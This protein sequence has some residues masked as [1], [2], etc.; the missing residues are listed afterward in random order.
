[1][2][3][4]N[5]TVN[6]VVSFDPLAMMAFQKSGSLSVLRESLQKRGGGSTHF[7]DNKGNSSLVSLTHSMD[8]EA[9]KQELSI[10]FID[11]ENLAIESLTRLDSSFEGN[12]QLKDNIFLKFLIEQRNSLLKTQIGLKNNF[13]P[14]GNFLVTENKYVKP[15]TELRNNISFVSGLI[16]G[17]GPS[18]YAEY[19]KVWEDGLPGNVPT[20]TA[21]EF[22][23]KL[24]DLNSSPAQRPVYVAYGIGENLR[25]WCKVK[26]FGP[27]QKAQYSFTSE[28]VKTLKFIFNP[29]EMH[30]TMMDV[31][32]NPLGH[33]AN[34]VRTVGRAF[35]LYNESI[36][37]SIKDKYKE[38]FWH[39]YKQSWDEDGLSFEITEDDLD[40][41]YPN[42][43][44]P[45]LYL[46]IRNV[47]TNFIKVATGY[48]NVL[49]LLPDLDKLLKPRLKELEKQITAQG[50]SKSTLVAQGNGPSGEPTPA[51]FET[52]PNTPSTVVK[53]EALSNILQLLG[54]EVTETRGE[55]TNT[56]TSPSITSLNL[57][58]GF[59]AAWTNKSYEEVFIDKQLTPTIQCNHTSQTV[60]EKLRTVADGIIKQVE[61]GTGRSLSFKNPYMETDYELL[62]ILEKYNLIDTATEP[63][64]I[65]GE[66]NF[67]SRYVQGRILLENSVSIKVPALGGF[68]EGKTPLRDGLV[69]LADMGLAPS[70][71]QIV[72]GLNIDYMKEVLEALE[73]SP[74]TDSLGGFIDYDD[75]KNNP[76]FPE[77]AKDAPRP[78]PVFLFGVPRS[79]ILSIDIDTDDT[80]AGVFKSIRP[81]KDVTPQTVG[82]VI[83]PGF[84]LEFQRMFQTWKAGEITDE[85]KRLVDEFWSEPVQGTGIINK[86]FKNWGRIFRNTFSSDTEGLPTGNEIFHRMEPGDSVL[87][88]ALGGWFELLTG[89]NEQWKELRIKLNKEKYYQF[90]W[91]AFTGLFSKHQEDLNVKPFSGKE[92]EKAAMAYNLALIERLANVSLTGRVKTLPMFYLSSAF[93]VQNRSCVVYC[94]E[95]NFAGT[96]GD[97]DKVSWISGM[98]TLFGFTHTINKSA[99]TSEFSLARGALAMTSDDEDYV[100]AKEFKEELEKLKDSIAN[101]DDGRATPM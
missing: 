65:W 73:T 70:P 34:D 44:E 42:K 71:F 58:Q 77:R 51:K 60:I 19:M 15:M 9:N 26:C 7:F 79:N 17:G 6:V 22:I 76:G 30:P 54:I 5:P 37:N 66:S 83:P 2:S 46:I 10:E 95:T 36:F 99:V 74:V 55:V 53:V 81:I 20:I 78:P 31:G 13:R 87:D 3:V 32:L 100:T 29:I 4:Y 69:H 92:P 93:D 25:S 96:S 40:S 57:P 86:N 35:T 68:A 39:I 84:G 98:Y 12:T 94:K 72:E 33:L 63:L 24:L 80:F 11:P 52:L 59:E 45:S 49:V 41:A 38:N 1:M 67:I 61:Q 90:M 27:I 56:L 18:N 47:I 48:K 14:T 88:T 97:A 101:L 23:Q 85:F 62:S 8:T 43:W 82:A 75:V 21:Y 28:G 16:D 89:E 91:D 50:G 64:L